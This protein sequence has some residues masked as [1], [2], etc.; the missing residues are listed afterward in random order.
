MDWSAIG[1][2][3]FYN[4]GVP[5]FALLVLI[6]LAGWLIKSEKLTFLAMVIDGQ[7]FFYC[8]TVIAVLLKD[9]HQRV[10]AGGAWIYIGFTGLLMVNVFIYGVVL[11]NPDRVDEKRVSWLSV[12]MVVF[13][14]ACVL[15]VRIPEG[16]L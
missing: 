16:L 13:S 14:V 5:L 7:L 15:G 1:L 10:E 12:T 2:W 6:P 3:L 11:T 9:L 8:V 4:V